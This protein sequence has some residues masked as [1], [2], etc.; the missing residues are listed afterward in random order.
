MNTA[1]FNVFRLKKSA[2]KL[3]QIQKIVI[4]SYSKDIIKLN[5]KEFKKFKVDELKLFVYTNI[6]YLLHIK[7]TQQSGGLWKEFRKFI[8]NSSTG[9]IFIID[10]VTFIINRY[11]VVAIKH[12][13]KLKFDQSARLKHDLLWYAGQFKTRN[14]C[15]VE[16][17]FSKNNFIVPFSLYREGIYIRK[18][19]YSDQILSST[20]NKHV[21]ISNLYVNSKLSR[22]EKIIQPVVVDENDNI[23]WIPG[24]IHG[25]INFNENNNVRIINWIRK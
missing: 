4:L 16:S 2:L 9:A 15:I 25:K 17:S 1:K 10:A 13:E 3:K 6:A 18:W 19:K 8:N 21:L 11:E 14:R 22:Y 7:L 23:L 20:L 12:F 5:R 24:L